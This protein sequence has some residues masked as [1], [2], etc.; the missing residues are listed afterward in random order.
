MDLG[1]IKGKSEDKCD[2][3]M[4]DILRELIKNSI[5]RKKEN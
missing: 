1:S 2:Q 5:L 4:Y 3:N